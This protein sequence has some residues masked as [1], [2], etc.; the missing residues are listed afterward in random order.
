ME[1]LAKHLHNGLQQLSKSLGTVQQQAR[2]DL[3]TL[4]K[5][6]LGLMKKG[7]E[8]LGRKLAND[9]RSQESRLR[10]LESDDP[11]S[12]KPPLSL[13][14]MVGRSPSPGSE[15]REPRHSAAPRLVRAQDHQG[16]NHPDQD[17]IEPH[18]EA[19][20]DRVQYQDPTSRAHPLD[21]GH[22]RLQS[23]P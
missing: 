13:P 21:S 23:T 4:E 1:A 9:I 14:R 16:F 22:R 19:H 18:L 2:D 11:R 17:P 20:N 3:K 5:H 7:L 6:Q 12:G 15:E 8:E 10:I